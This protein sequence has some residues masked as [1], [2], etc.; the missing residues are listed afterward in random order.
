MHNY[1]TPTTLTSKFKIWA[2]LPPLMLFPIIGLTYLLLISTLTHQTTKTPIPIYFVIGLFIFTLVWLVFGELRTKII[3]VTVDD[4]KVMSSSF[5]GLGPHKSFHFDELD[6][7][8]ISFLPS[9]SGTYEYMYL[10]LKGKKAVKISEFYH[11][12][13]IELKQSLI[14]KTDDLGTENFSYLK[15]LREIF[16]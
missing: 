9:R 14:L 2:F 6:G 1:K 7:F 10:M 16:E 12:N 11:R 13:Y 4:K 5:L 15:E 8:K 3:K